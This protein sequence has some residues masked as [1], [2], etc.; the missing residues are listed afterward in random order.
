M[1]QKKG[2][3]SSR[4]KGNRNLT[5]DTHNN[6]NGL[7]SNN[8]TERYPPHW[9][10]DDCRTAYASGT[11]ATT[12]TV[13]VRGILR[14]LPFS[15]QNAAATASFVTCD[16]GETG[17]DICVATE[18]DRNRALHGDEVFI[19]LYPVQ[20]VEDVDESAEEKRPLTSV[21]IQ[22]HLQ[23]MTLD[24][25]GNDTCDSPVGPPQTWQDDPA[26]AALWNPVVPIQRPTANGRHTH[27]EDPMERRRRK[28]QQMQ[29][30]RKGRV[31][32]I[33]PPKA[34]YSE[35]QTSNSSSPQ[36]PPT[37][38]IVGT[39]KMLPDGNTI[40]L[41]PNNRSLSQFRC[42]TEGTRK[43]VE[44]AKQQDEDCDINQLYF[45]A[46]YEHGSWL[47]THKWPSVV[48]VKRLGTAF[49]LDD[50][51]Q[52]LLT[53]YDLDH[54]DFFPDVLRDVNAAVKSGVYYQSSS[55]SGGSTDAE[56]GWKPT[57]S[58][59]Q[60]RRDYR[61]ERIFTIDPTTAKD[62]DDALHIRLLDDGCIE[63]GVHIADVSHFVRPGTAVDTEAQRRSTTVYLV[64]RTVP[65]LPRPLCEIACSL[66]E[67]VERLAFSCVWRMNADGTL[68]TVS[69]GKG[70]DVWYG[71]TVIKSCARLDYS[72]AQNIIENKVA[73]GEAVDT[74][75]DDL[76]PSARRPT[77]DHTVDQVAADVRLMHRVA[78]ARRRVRFDNGA[79]GLHGI[80]LTFQLGTDGQTPLLTAPYPIRD[81]NRLV[82]E[83]MLLANY[84][85]AQRL[86]THSGGR[87]VLR[88]HNEP[89]EDGLGDLAAVAKA[90]IGFD[91]DV[92]SS[93]TLHAS[94]VRL[95][96]ECKD[97]LVLQC[98]TQMM[99]TPMVPA[100]YFAAGTLEAEEWRHFALNI[101]Y[102]THFTSP[103]RRYPDV[104]VHRLLQAT[105]DGPEAVDRF[106]L[107]VKMT[108]TTCKHCND[109]RMKSK[110]AQER[111]DRVFLALFVKVHPIRNQLGVVL[112]VGR[113]TFTVFVPSL[114]VNAILYL[115]EHKDM[116]TFAIEEVSR[117]DGCSR[118]ILLQLKP[119][120]AKCME[121]SRKW[122][123]GALEIKVFS[124][125][126]V[127][128]TCK[129]K[130]PVD[131]KLRLEG[132]WKE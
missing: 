97:P 116:L 74:M 9:S 46:E 121:E 130:P 18:V 117:E 93:Q 96:R 8:K 55:N 58:M 52:A 125:L 34:V 89:A 127:T 106:Y 16:R 82:E 69:G 53:E 20:E 54:G 66:N 79:L 47:T 36:K 27:D 38:R 72:T 33:V 100:N 87:A 70:E 13:V 14:V 12:K 126:A 75:K 84:L 111:C 95:G 22:E 104:M 90:A 1:S 3:S 23:D 62:L 11:S 43:L 17:K 31:V 110:K 45:C 32:Y 48:R 85:V 29:Q 59:Y 65:M 107:D 88:C 21:D 91:I 39:L 129:D 132:P 81:S 35:V 118:R 128:V 49:V 98:I 68:Q 5:D 105:I 80:K 83:F 40:L 41:T 19:E 76:W 123:S 44:L 24:E 51:V 61:S 56:L 103:I 108:E 101:P 94:L 10:L 114:G 30:Q 102:Y 77:G 120:A 124:K 78:M 26:Q 37:R 92:S 60:G 7:P 6:N 4:R 122:Q 15:P 64:D 119:E 109:K 25:G 2:G 67:N 28:E 42:P 57:P 113:S 50:E 86:I 71:R 73:T 63:V 99:M 131:V 112:S 115:D